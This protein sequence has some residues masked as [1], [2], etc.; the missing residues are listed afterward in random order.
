MSDIQPQD[1][2]P[3]QE[4]APDAT[5]PSEK[6]HKSGSWKLTLLICVV[7]LAAAG[8]IVA[9]T[10]S[11]EPT[12]QKSGATK[13]TAMLVEVTSV[14]RGDYR[15]EIVA[16]GTVEPAQDVVLR[17]QVGGRIT[18]LAPA[19]TPGGYVAQGDLL[20]RIEPADFRHVLAQR[21]SDL[22][23]ALSEL[24]VEKGRTEAAKVE[25]DYIDEELEP[26]NEALVLRKPQLEAAK[27]RVS[28]ARAA[29]EQAELDLRRTS[30]EA[31]FDAHIIRRDA[32]VGSQVSPNESIG[33]L[34]GVDE[35]WVGVELPLSKLRWVEVARN[36]ED[37]PEGS[38]VRVR[39]RQAWPK[40]AFRTGHLFRTVGALDA[41]TRMARVLA[42]IPDPLARQST[43]DGQPKQPLMIGEFVE[44]TI[45]G[46]P[47]DNVVRLDRD[48]VRANDTVWV[49]KDGKLEVRPVDIAVRD[50]Q[51]AYITDGLDDG[52]Q[53]V[54]TNLSTVV[55]GSPLR[56]DGAE[57]NNAEQ[58]GAEQD[59]AEQEDAEQEGA[60]DE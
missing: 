29:V 43:D 27:E 17:P 18:E 6:E 47:V 23:Q 13:K 25:Y 57:H 11:T 22:R 45:E 48:Y 59:G 37:S 41:Q 54:T 19:F 26:E 4:P 20:V 52:E 30:V 40:D 58:D 3:D 32:N 12:A 10:F 35:Y 9:L 28:A 24:A 7:I 50:A 1:M 46:K 56:L 39:N 53:V 38:K 34:V 15:P 49:M 42:T 55:D 44:V 8:G 16:Q 31:P 2:Q 60:G 21:K 51:Y 5:A 14:E 36:G 33:R